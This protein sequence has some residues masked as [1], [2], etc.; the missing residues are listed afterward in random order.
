MCEKCQHQCSCQECMAPEIKP[1]LTE[2]IVGFIIGTVFFPHLLMLQILAK[3]KYK[4]EMMKLMNNPEAQKKM[5]EYMLAQMFSQMSQQSF[6][7]DEELE[8]GEE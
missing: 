5:A 3:K 7:E 4:K 1:S 2:K 6:G 8:Q